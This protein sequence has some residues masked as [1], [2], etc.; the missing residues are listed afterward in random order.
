ML[1]QLQIKRYFDR[2]AGQVASDGRPVRFG[3]AGREKS[4]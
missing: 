2:A 4:P 1:E 3:L